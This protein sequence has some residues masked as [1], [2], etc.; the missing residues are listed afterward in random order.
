MSEIAAGG[1]QERTAAHRRIDDP[2]G[3]D[4]VGR[5]A[6]YERRERAP[7]DEL[8]QRLRRVERTRF[9]AASAVPIAPVRRPRARQ[10]LRANHF[11]RIEIEHAFVDR[12]ELLDAEIRVRDRLAPAGAW[13]RAKRR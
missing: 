12:A 7:D 9:L 10:V 11:V 6:A 2:K 4:V 3:E 8:R 13:S 5:R 1:D